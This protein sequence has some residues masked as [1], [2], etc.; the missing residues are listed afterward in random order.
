MYHEEVSASIEVN[1]TDDQLMQ[2]S[3]RLQFQNS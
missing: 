1:N 3:N 2:R